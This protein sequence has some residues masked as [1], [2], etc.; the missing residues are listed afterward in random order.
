MPSRRLSRRLYNGM[1]NR[2]DANTPIQLA[3]LRPIHIGNKCS[4]ATEWPECWTLRLQD[5]SPTGHFAYYVDSS[6]THCEHV[7]R[8][9]M[10]SVVPTGTA[11]RLHPDDVD[12][13]DIMAT[14]RLVS[15]QGD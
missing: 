10:S 2:R 9:L 8:L 11:G 7:L 4:A 1:C 3:T 14:N 5:I 6:P 15:L 12:R 13:V